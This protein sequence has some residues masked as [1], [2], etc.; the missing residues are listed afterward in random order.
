MT[1]ALTFSTFPE[2][3]TSSL[4]RFPLEKSNSCLSEDPAF[5]V[6][7]SSRSS[8]ISRAD[9]LTSLTKDDPFIPS[10]FSR[11]ATTP[12]SDAV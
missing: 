5:L 3:S 10:S 8:L 1:T 7:A 6:L 2:N 4:S 12:A 9:F 11:T